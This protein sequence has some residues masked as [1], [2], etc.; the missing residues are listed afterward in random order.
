M[1]SHLLQ[2]GDSGKTIISDLTT[3][4]NLMSVVA[5]MSELAAQSALEKWEANSDLEEGDEKLKQRGVVLQEA[6][7]V[8]GPKLCEKFSVGSALVPVLLHCNAIVQSDEGVTTKRIWTDDLTRTLLKKSFSH[9]PLQLATA[10]NSEVTLA[11]TLTAAV[12]MTTPDAIQTVFGSEYSL[13]N[14]LSGAHGVKTKPPVAKDA[15]ISRVLLAALAHKHEIA[16]KKEEQSYKAHANKIR[17]GT[18]PS[19]KV[20]PGSRPS[21][22]GAR[23]AASEIDKT[24]PKPANITPGALYITMY[25]YQRKLKKNS[26]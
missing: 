13:L 9:S 26:E 24:P 20:T 4:C 10:A 14:K 22:G 8:V 16:N 3:G 11:T 25:W 17:T 5:I 21:I 2:S 7:A 18:K 12:N 19:V 6:K 15:L 1:L 23:S